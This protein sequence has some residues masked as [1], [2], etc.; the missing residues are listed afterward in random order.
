MTSFLFALSHARTHSYTVTV[1]AF[2]RSN[3]R[4]QLLIFKYPVL[5][6]PKRGALDAL[7]TLLQVKVSASL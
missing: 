1:Y 3:L 4:K 6:G 5:Y 2:I 7:I